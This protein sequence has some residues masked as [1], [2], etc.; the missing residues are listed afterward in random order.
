MA[1]EIPLKAVLSGRIEKL[2]SRSSGFVSH[3]SKAVPS[4]CTNMDFRTLAIILHLISSHDETSRL[5]SVSKS[6]RNLKNN[7]L[8]KKRFSLLKHLW[9]EQ[10]LSSG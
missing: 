7:I 10:S 4:L 9:R 1:R 5:D 2:D 3:H 6:Y 8:A